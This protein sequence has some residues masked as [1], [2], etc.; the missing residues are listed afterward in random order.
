MVSGTSGGAGASGSAPTTILGNGFGAAHLGAGAGETNFVGGAGSQLLFGGQGA[1]ILTYLA[2]GD[3]GDRVSNFDPAKDVIDLSHIDADITTAGVQNFT[4][5]GTAAFSGG[6]QVRYQLNPTN[7]TT[8]VQAALAGDPSADFSIVIAGLAPLTAANFALTSAQSS[9]DLADGAA[10]TYSRVTT[11]AGAPPEYAYSNV[12]GRAYTSFEE[13]YGSG[14]ATADD[15]NLSSSTNELVLYQP[16]LTVT[17]GGGSEAL[18]AGT[19]SDP[20]SY[21]AV[22]TIDANT[23]AANNSSSAR[24]SATKRSMAFQLR[25]QVRTQSSCRSRHSPT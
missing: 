20:L 24:A 3:G 17:R 14:F 12:Q 10:L 15:L 25:A 6:A 1:N 13:F 16:S 5:I 7:N 23:R 9:A 2:I 18:Q 22:E 19:G 4:F 11:A 21:H 8:T